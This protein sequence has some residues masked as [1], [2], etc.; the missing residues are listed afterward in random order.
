M[1]LLK[2]KLVLFIKSESDIGPVLW[3][4]SGWYRLYFER[5]ISLHYI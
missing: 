1:L 4:Y 5:V 3:V 2:L